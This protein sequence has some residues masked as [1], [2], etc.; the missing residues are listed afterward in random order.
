MSAADN[1]NVSKP[2]ESEDLDPTLPD[3]LGVGENLL[4]DDVFERILATAMD[5]VNELADDSLIPPEDDPVLTDDGEFLNPEE[6][7]L[8]LGDA[9]IDLDDE[10]EE[11]EVEFEDAGHHED[12][13]GG[14]FGEDD[15]SVDGSGGSF[16]L[17]NDSHDEDFGGEWS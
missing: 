17:D 4:P 12:H 11:P 5:S 8:L 13:E 7:E 6:A 3:L 2:W 9:D 15:F 14:F 16:D 10:E 1:P